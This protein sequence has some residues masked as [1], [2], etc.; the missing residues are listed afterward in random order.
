MTWI[1]YRG[2]IAGIAISL[3][4]ALYLR[5][6]LATRGGDDSVSV[7]LLSILV[8]TFLGGTGGYGIRRASEQHR[9]VT[10]SASTRGKVLERSEDA[11]IRV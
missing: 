7:T 1:G 5:Q 6:R 8:M 9:L 3:G 2:Q 10:T 11:P 4:G